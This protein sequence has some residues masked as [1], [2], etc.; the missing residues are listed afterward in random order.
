MSVLHQGSSFSPLPKCVPRS[1]AQN[2]KHADQLV[3]GRRAMI[4]ERL[5][6]PMSVSHELAGVNRDILHQN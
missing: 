6:H 2:C 5:L 4:H 1:N 3:R